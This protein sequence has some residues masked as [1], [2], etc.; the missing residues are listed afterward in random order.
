[1][2]PPND[3][4]DAALLAPPPGVRGGD[5]PLLRPG[6]TCWRVERGGRAAFLLDSAAYFAAAREAMLQARRSIL[7]LGWDFDPRTRLRPGA[8]GSG[9][10]PD[11]PDEIGPFLKALIERRPDL[12]VRV[13]VWDMPMLIE[14]GRDLSPRKEPE[15]FR[16]SAVRFRLARAPAGAC[17]HQKLLVVDGAVAFC[18]GGDFATNRWDTPRHPDHD[19][20][21]REPSGEEHEPRHEVMVLVEGP[22]AAAL[23]ALARERWRGAERGRPGPDAEDAPPRPRTGAAPWPAGVRADLAEA[24]R[25]GIARTKPEWERGLPAREGEALHLAAIAAAR[26]FIYLEN[27]YFASERIASALAWRLAEPDGPEVVLVLPERSPAAVERLAM[28][29]PR[30]ALLARLRAAD[31]HGRFAAY[32]PRTP[33]GRTVIVHSKVAV[34]DDALLRVGSANLNNRSAGY[35]TECCLALEA[36]PGDG[37]EAARAREAIRRFRERLIGHYLGVDGDRFAEAAVAAGGLARGIEA[38][39]AGAR[40]RR[41]VPLAPDGKLDPLRALVARWHLFDPHGTGDAWRP[42]RRRA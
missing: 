7:L 31:R 26:R 35:D 8:E 15:W 17:H 9:P 28:D 10:A 16:D 42:W 5:G 24:P 3:F 33:G 38:L 27:Q 18:G 21:R 34:I 25:V 12:E 37:P 32:A 13:L 39:E 41:L 6:E 2:T 1:M 40:N 20:R 22:P 29:S 36:P 23:D 11:L 19:P 14:G 4:Q 30:A